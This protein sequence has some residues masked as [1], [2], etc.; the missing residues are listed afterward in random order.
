MAKSINIDQD[1]NLESSGLGEIKVAIGSSN[2]DGFARL[3]VS[4]ITTQLDAK[5]LYDKLPLFIDEELIGTATATHS[6]TLARTQLAVAATNDAVIMQT[7]Q[8]FNYQSGKSQQLFWTFHSLGEGANIY[9]KVNR[10]GVSVDSVIRAS[11]DDP[12]DGTGRSGVTHDFDNN[13]I[14]MVDFEWL[15]VGNIRWFVIKNGLPILFHELDHTGTTEVYMS[16]PNKPMRWELRQTGASAYTSRVGYFTSNNTT[17]FNSTLDGFWIE[18]NDAGATFDYICASVNTEGSINQ[19]G[20]IL[21]Y[22][23]GTAHIN[24]SSTANKY[25]IIGF[26]LNA[27]NADAL[28]DLLDYSLLSITNDNMLIEVWLNPTVAGTFTYASVTNSSAQVAIGAVAGTNTVTGGTL[29]ASSYGTSLDPVNSTI[30]NAIRL[31]STIDGSL[32][33]LVITANPLTSNLDVLG[34]INWREL[35]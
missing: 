30:Q 35:T 18:S 29:L 27:S 14:M 2:L 25:A 6:T 3:R 20:K 17:P 11:W 9:L 16:S 24:A 22:N 8:R 33:T 4:Q 34:S 12:L 26:R 32:D 7:K 15:G 23:L 19:I 13:T 21:S 1:D 28:I 5:Q 10:T 31:G